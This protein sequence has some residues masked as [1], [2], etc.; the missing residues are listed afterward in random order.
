M[1]ELE[2]AGPEPRLAAQRP[3]VDIGVEGLNFVTPGA[4]RFGHGGVAAPGHDMDLGP[5]HGDL[6]PRAGILSGRRLRRIER[7]QRRRAVAPHMGVE[8]R[9]QIFRHRDPIGC[10]V[11]GFG[12]RDGALEFQPRDFHLGVVC[13]HGGEGFILGNAQARRIPQR[14]NLGNRHLGGAGIE[15]DNGQ[16]YDNQRYGK[17]TEIH[18]VTP[19]SGWRRGCRLSGKG[20]NSVNKI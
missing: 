20:E 8:R 13:R 19:Q 5:E 4:G 17:R 18:L 2:V 10:G 1:G 11:A 15:R 9:R 12:G 16:R 3:A 14:R 7:R 6:E